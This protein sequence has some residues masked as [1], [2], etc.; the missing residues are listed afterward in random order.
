MSSLVQRIEKYLMLLL[1]QSNGSLKLKRNDLADQFNC[2]PSQINYV[3]KTRFSI[4]RGFLVES[5]RGGGGY[6]RIRELK[7]DHPEVD[8]MYVVLEI[9][10]DELTQQQMVNLLHNLEDKKIITQREKLILQAVLNRQ[11]L[12][13]DLPYRDYLRAK[14]FKAAL[15]AIMKS[16]NSQ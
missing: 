2:V 13:I 10:G 4:E 7:F 11:N 12:S 15:G 5:Q 3:L 16:E 1:N 14:L 8:F 6:V 9:I